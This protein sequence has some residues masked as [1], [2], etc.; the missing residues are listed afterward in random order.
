MNILQ[1]N[2]DHLT[3]KIDINIDKSKNDDILK[4][5][6]DT[7]QGTKHSIISTL[8]TFLSISISISIDNLSYNSCICL[9]T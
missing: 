8:N 5:E 1:S 2:V 7:N 3:K 4:Y 6:H 9:N